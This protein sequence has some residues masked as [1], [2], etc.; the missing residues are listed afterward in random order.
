[1]IDLQQETSRAV[2]QFWADHVR[3]RMDAA[4]LAD[5]DFS[6][7]IS[8]S[9]AVFCEQRAHMPEPLLSLLLARSFCAT[10]NVDAAGRILRD[11]RLY[12]A[13]TDTWLS[14]LSAK[15]PFP[16][17]S[18]LFSSRT[19]RPVQLHTVGPVSTWVLDLDRIQVAPAD[20]HELILFQTLRALVEKVS[21]VWEQTDGQGTLA[22]KGMSKLSA[23]L[24]SYSVQEFLVYMGDILQ[25]RARKNGW[26]FR[27]AVLLL[28]L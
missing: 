12:R 11:D 20:Q 25:E 4:D 15:Y 5:R 10:G 6:V 14:A 3:H 22:V 27:P 19:L 26:T 16:E 23:G 17:L 28:D 2:R 24:D 8:E 18:L 9:L 7:D 21:N 1:M 13:H